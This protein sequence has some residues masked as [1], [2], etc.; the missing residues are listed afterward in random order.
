MKWGNISISDDSRHT[1]SLQPSA[2]LWFHP[3]VCAPLKCLS[4]VRLGGALH[5]LQTLVFS[6]VTRPPGIAVKLWFCFSARVAFT[7]LMCERKMQ[8]SLL[9]VQFSCVLMY[10]FFFLFFKKACLDDVLIQF[11]LLLLTSCSA[12]ALC[13][14]RCLSAERN[15]S[16]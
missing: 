5:P 1:C 6:F 9:M 16:K 13:S 2:I 8:T 12:L 11:S 10:F 4:G 14:I 7:A 3:L 15:V